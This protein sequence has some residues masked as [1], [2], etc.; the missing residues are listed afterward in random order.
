M[1]WRDYLK[2]GVHL[3]DR[4]YIFD[5]T[6][7]DG[8]QTPEVSLTPEEKLAIAKQLDALGV[9]VIEAGFPVISKGEMEAVKMISEAGLEAE[10]CGLARA[11][12]RD[13]DAA[14]DCGVDCV[15]TFIA[16]SEVH[17]AKKLK[18]TREEVLAKAVE[19][20][21][22]AKSRGVVVEFSAEDATRS[23]WGFLV[24]VYKAVEGAGADRINVPD[25]VGFAV[26]RA[27]FQ[28][29]RRL[30]E[31]VRI[32]ISV[33]CHNDMGLAVANSLAGVEAGAEQVHATI[34]G[35]GER[36]GNASLEELAVCLKILYGIQTNIKLSELYRTSQMV[37]S[38]TGV[39]IQPNKAIVGSNAFAHESGI[40]THGVIS[41]PDTYE[42]ISPEL[43]GRSRRLV[44]GKH[45]GRHGVEEMLRE[46]GFSLTKQ[47]LDEILAKVKEIGDK[48]GKVT[49]ADLASMAEALTGSLPPEERRIKLEDLIVVTG[50]KTTP[51]ATV[52][53]L[54]DGKEYRSSHFG[55]GPIDAAIKAVKNVV[56]E[57]AAF[58]LVE[59]R[60]DSITGGTE[61]LANV[62]VKLA[63]ESGRIVSTRA[64]REDI[65]MAGVEAIIN[66]ANRLLYLKERKP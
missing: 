18:M 36:A 21:E 23:D 49:D 4:V 55:V 22:Y 13:I 28:L 50:N 14:V 26:P 40:H 7:R 44:A 9:D 25:T 5:T 15:H 63:D 10:I 52:R 35:L 39:L 41:S 53:L 62:I 8:E 37:S 20:V 31:E 38:M 61:A 57:V 16:T 47:Q 12:Q 66:A 30:K 24:E 3:P 29:I 17:M 34:N 54:I 43:V 45:A 65:V 60:L 56:S 11:V 32:P 27:M 1:A 33:H 19:A 59:F 6:L 46:M 42:P 2:D 64:V 51:V 58:D 48:G